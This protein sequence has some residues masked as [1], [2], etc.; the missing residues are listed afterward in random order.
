VTVT[1]GNTTRVRRR[2]SP[3]ER[4]ERLLDAACRLIVQQGFLPLTMEQIG[5]AAH[6][7]KAL[8]YTY[9]PAQYD[10]YNA[11]LERQVRALDAAGF[12]A[13]TREQQL[14]DALTRCV[15]VYFEH[16]VRWGP[17]L[18]ILWSDLYM[19]GHTE[20]E[21]VHWR[22]QRMRR[23]ARLAR[24]ELSLPAVEASA[25][26]ELVMTIPE[27]TGRL[28]F[29]GDID[30]NTARELCTQLTLSALGSLTPS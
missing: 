18:H 3:S 8:V 4:R 14:R 1:K 20:A 9:F 22:A 2:L 7:S 15:V 12:D 29:H 24:A 19:A 28:A 23:L 27:E 17:L 10:I 26:I 30:Q 6:V 5:R 21:L 16:I 25:A 13:A 11:A